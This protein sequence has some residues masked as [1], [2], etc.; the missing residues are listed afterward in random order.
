MMRRTRRCAAAAWAATLALIAAG[1][2]ASD[3]A[4]RALEQRIA[5]IAQLLGDTPAMQ[6]IVA[7]GHTRALSWLDE[8]R[9]LHAMSQE[10]VQRGDLAAARRA[11]DDA[12]RAISQARRLVPDAP[13]RQAAARQRH[14]SLL[15]HLER[16]I[17]AW[18]RR[19]P[20]GD[21]DDGDR[22]AALG[23]IDTA[24]SLAAAGRYEE[25]V[26]VLGS[27][28]SHVLAGMNRLLRQA[29]LHEIDYT[30]RPATEAERWQFELQRH[31]EL[32]DLVP[33]AVD[34][35]RPRAEAQALIVRYLQAAST[36][37]AQAEQQRRE[38][39]LAQ[40]QLHLRN[41]TLYLD[42]ALAAAGVLTPAPIG[43]TK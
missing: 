33:L 19:A 37:R 14:D 36:L 6:R 4:R 25:S 30:Q 32:A 20:P 21:A 18:R 8:G 10:A 13:A 43:E 22:Y 38:G 3:D 5:L 24:R 35:M 34:E 42:R 39:S 29:G 7:S 31:D 23:L 40:A 27:A 2:Q 12:L 28:E 16:V 17:E 1:S 9:L 41:A 11:A 26:Q 15:A